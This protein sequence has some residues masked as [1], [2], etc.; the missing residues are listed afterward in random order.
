MIAARCPLEIPDPA[1]SAGLQVSRRASSGGNDD[2][3]QSADDVLPDLYIMTVAYG[4][5]GPGA[6]RNLTIGFMV[7][8][9]VR[10]HVQWVNIDV[11]SV[12]VHNG[13]TLV[14]NI[15]AL[16]GVPFRG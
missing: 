2:Q 7:V 16:F 9:T 8:T 6:A 1:E 12:H 10:G 14:A 13:I 5:E 15:R 11:F 3:A 4:A